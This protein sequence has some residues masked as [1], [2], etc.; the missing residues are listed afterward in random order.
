MKSA[1]AMKKVDAVAIGGFDGMHE[2]HQH[3]FEALGDQGAIVVIETG[4]ANLTP[5]REREHFT[6]L[7]VVYLPLEAIRHFNDRQFVTHL[8]SR[9]P[10]LRRIVVGYDFR[11]G[12]DRRYTHEDLRAA[13]DG[14]VV[15]IDAVRIGGDAVHSHKIRAKLIIGDI[16]AAN[17]FL[18]HNYTI[19]GKVVAGQGLGKKALYATINMQTDGFLL[20]KEGVYA[21]V[22]RI[23]GQEHYRPAVSFIGHRVTT[24]GSFAVETHLL[25]GETEGVT[26]IAVS[27]LTRLRDNI[28]FDSLEALRQAITEDIAKAR[29]AHGRLRL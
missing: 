22:A 11:F 7:P 10:A 8:T 20:P 24:D 13:F 5:G 3:L 26:Q 14:A 21:T 29:V 4:Y 27:F 25:D 6:A 23:D 12:K 15:V 18:G 1:I 19:R 9:F 17:R 16:P 28:R 2:G